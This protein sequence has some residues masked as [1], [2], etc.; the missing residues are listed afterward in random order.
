MRVTDFLRSVELFEDIPV[1]QLLELAPR[2][3]DRILQPG[4]VLFSEGDVCEAIYV[5]AGGF[6]DLS[7]AAPSGF[8]RVIGTVR[9]GATLGEAEMMTDLP[10]SVT[11]TAGTTSRV[12]C[13]DRRVLS[14]LVG[15]NPGLLRRLVASVGRQSMATS[16]QLLNDERVGLLNGTGRIHV[17][18]G[19]RGGSG[20][21]TVA[22]NMAAVMA[23]TYPGRV[24]LLD[25]SAPFSHALLAA[26]LDSF[27][28]LAVLTNS[29]LLE[30]DTGNFLA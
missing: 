11:V 10:H 12:L 29:L 17:V 24:A 13:V 22:L 1:E 23:R 8:P 4:D 19:P 2:I 3:Q 20:R 26:G 25:L 27:T 7:L 21:T 28:T 15:E 6:L 30:T 18:Y 14:W 9:D 16:S 5:V